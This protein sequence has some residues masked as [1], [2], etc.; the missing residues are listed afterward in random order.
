LYGEFKIENKTI[1][2]I[3]ELTKEQK[4]IFSSLKIKEPSTILNIYDT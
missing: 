2:Q 3:T 4:S 1:C